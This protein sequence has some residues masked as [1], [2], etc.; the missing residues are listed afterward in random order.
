MRICT[1]GSGIVHFGLSHVGCC[2]SPRVVGW[3]LK[4]F[5]WLVDS[6]LFPPIRALLERNN[7]F[8]QTLAETEVPESPLFLP[9]HPAPNASSSAN[10]SKHQS[11]SE[12]AALA[13]GIPGNSAFEALPTL[14]TL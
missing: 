12:M 10:Q 11:S 3:L 4:F 5:V 7:K 9:V 8:P 6:W 2:R 13:V 1:E 14:S